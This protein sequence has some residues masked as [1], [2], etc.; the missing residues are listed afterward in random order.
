MKMEN[1]Q[2]NKEEPQRIAFEPTVFRGYL[3]RGDLKSAISYVA[4]FPEKQELY[5]RYQ[6]LF[7]QEH[8]L[9]YGIPDEL[10]QILLAY[11]KYIREVLYCGRSV[12]DAEQ[13][14]LAD[15]KT[16][17]SVPENMTLE[18]LD[19][20]IVPQA[21]TEKGYSCLTGQTGSYYGPYVWRSTEH[22]TFSV[23]LPDGVEQY[24]ICF[25]DGFIF[26]SWLAYISFD[27]IGTGGW[28]AGD[29]TICCVRSAYN[30][31]SESFRVSLLKHEAQHEWDKSHYGELPSQELEYRAKLVELIYSEE[32]NLLKAFLA[33]ADTSDM[34]NSHALAANQI[35]D[36]FVE[37]TECSREQ[38]KDLPVS[39][40]QT[41]ARNL[42]RRSTESLEGK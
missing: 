30:T 23:E 34:G 13:R 11:Q 7:E 5:H 33:E 15:L 14:L 41:I 40:V 31:D 16:L 17:F 24:P 28:S 2:K 10:N 37:L 19:E 22:A 12:S 1:S 36:G 6:E 18:Q 3:I 25:L 26:R 35:V 32:R 9:V 4:Q 42:F 20:E 39:Q 8:Y 21:F 27:E 38:L 29:G